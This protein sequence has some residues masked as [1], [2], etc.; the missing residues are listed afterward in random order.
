MK[1]ATFRASYPA[2][3]LHPVHRAL[4]ASDASRMELLMWGPTASVS[5]LSWLDAGPETAAALFDAVPSKTSAEFIAEEEGTYAF[6]HQSAYE[7][8]DA[9]MGALGAAPVVF[10][11]PVVFEADGTATFEAV[12][13]AAGVSA[14]YDALNEHL[15]VSIERA[16][17]FRR[18][19]G[20][21]DLTA[22]QREALRVAREVGYYDVPRSG[23]VA[24]V[25]DGL[26]CAPSTAGEL[27]RKAER[28]VVSE[29]V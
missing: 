22:R 5:S 6:V 2:E 26:G 13:G 16:R 12:G 10:L 23:S 18:A 27:L 25:A 4:T 19:G 14:L 11:P 21:A 15:A 7:F 24:D 20:G 1:R 29:H 17:P 8:D 28:A 3:L 9:L